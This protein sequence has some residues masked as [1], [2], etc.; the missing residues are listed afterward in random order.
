[1]H[2]LWFNM[3]MLGIEAQQVIWLRTMKLVM[4]GKRGEREARRMV[5]EKV[6]AAGQASVQI[7]RG[8]SPDKVVKGYRKKVRANARRLSR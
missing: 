2:R 7:A 1:M 3:A 5:S 8:A 4:G 6:A